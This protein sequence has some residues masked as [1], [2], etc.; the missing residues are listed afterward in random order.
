M[1]WYCPLRHPSTWIGGQSSKSFFSL[2]ES[3]LT[4][5]SIQGLLWLWWER[6]SMP[7]AT[8]HASRSF[9]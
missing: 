6:S 1:G 2:P 3:R 4:S 5:Y 9:S 8:E 7:S